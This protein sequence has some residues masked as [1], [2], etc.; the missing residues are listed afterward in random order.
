MGRVEESDEEGRAG[1]MGEIRRILGKIKKKRCFESVFA[2][3]RER[4]LNGRRRDEKNGKI[5]R[6][7]SLANARPQTSPRRRKIVGISEKFRLRVAAPTLAN[8]RV[9]IRY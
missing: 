7:F 5:F 2:Y 3:R 1:K 8:R 9:L 6:K 4:T